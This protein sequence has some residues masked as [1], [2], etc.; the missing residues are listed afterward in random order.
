[1]SA[2]PSADF[3]FRFANVPVGNFRVTVQG[4][5]AVAAGARPGSNAVYIKE[6][7]FDGADVLNG[8][9]RISGTTS[10]SLDIVIGV[11]GGQISGTLTDRRS[12][13]VPVTQVVLIPDRS[14]DRTELYRTVNTDENG[15]FNF[16]GITPGDYKVFSW[17]GLEPYG[18]FDPDV[19]A[20]SEGKGVS[21]RVTESSAEM[22]DVKL[23]PREVAQ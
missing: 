8:P 19:M 6:A 9:L 22:I 13:P 21:V 11:G 12:Q 3:T 18:W 5:G 7:R 23:I 10:G 17:E 15:R 4:Q 20:Q 2:T 14:R 1:V 16:I